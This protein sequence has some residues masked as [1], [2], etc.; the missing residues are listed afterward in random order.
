VIVGHQFTGEE[1]MRKIVLQRVLLPIVVAALLPGCAK[2]EP[3][4]T[5]ASQAASGAVDS[6]VLGADLEPEVLTEIH[7]LDE[8]QN[9][10]DG[11]D[12]T[13]R[14]LN[15]RYA[16]DLLWIVP[17]GRKYGSRAEYQAAFQFDEKRGGPVLA[18]LKGAQ[19]PRAIPASHDEV[20]SKRYGDIVV[21]SG[22]SVTKDPNPG[23]GKPVGGARRY[24]RVFA[25]RDGH[26]WYVAS[27]STP[28]G[29]GRRP[30][31][32][33]LAE[34]IAAASRREPAA[35]K[36]ILGQEVDPKVQDEILRLDAAQDEA[37]ATGD[38]DG[39]LNRMVA[40]DV[41]WTKPSGARFE[42][43]AE[44]LA[45]V[46]SADQKGSRTPNTRDEFRMK[47]YGDA[48]VQSGRSTT[49]NPDQSLGSSSRYMN[50]FLNRR[51]QWW[52]VAHTATPVLTSG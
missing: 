17:S 45:D 28:V 41:L 1:Q 4:E 35:N 26:W 24:M 22:R 13:Q 34:A 32:P 43:K 16:D 48:I 7:R 42:S 12:E 18:K 9:E 15:L 36:A 46:R 6:A 31:P 49:V 38:R 2:T 50:V 40:D 3:K 27:Q 23:P 37:A 14:L 8:A 20:R 51:G 5:S 10:D 52:M 44:L 21:H 25:F 47:R 39:A 19:E 30:D 33:G 29:P 11:S